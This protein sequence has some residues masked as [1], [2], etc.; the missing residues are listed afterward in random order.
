MDLKFSELVT[1]GP[2]GNNVGPSGNY[3]KTI[4]L[5]PDVNL[6]EYVPGSSLVN[7]IFANPSALAASTPDDAVLID[8]LILSRDSNKSVDTPVL[9]TIS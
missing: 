6:K 9:V 7:V 4:D 3:V 5:D 8:R 1:V 2:S